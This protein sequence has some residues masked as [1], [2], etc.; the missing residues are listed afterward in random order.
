MFVFQQFFKYTQT[1]VQ[2]SPLGNSKVT[3]IYRSTLQNILG[4]LKFCMGSCPVTV[5][6]RVTA[7]Y[8]DVIYSFDCTCKD[9]KVPNRFCGI[10][11]LPYLKARIE[12]L[13]L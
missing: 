6:N 8:R 3:A 11:D 5:K 7:L 9:K 1:C 2:R 13:K 4:N 12:I 10:R